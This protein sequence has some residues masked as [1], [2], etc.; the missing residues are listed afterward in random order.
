MKDDETGHFFHKT[1]T[2][3]SL[4]CIV[5][6]VELLIAT[7]YRFHFVRQDFRI[8]IGLKGTQIVR[9][10]SGRTGVMEKDPKGP[11]GDKKRQ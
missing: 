11:K 9:I 10:I 5:A 7:T 8:S 4:Q 6:R 2:P 3:P 1:F